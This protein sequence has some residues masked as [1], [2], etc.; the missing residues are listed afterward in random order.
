MFAKAMGVTAL[1]TVGSQGSAQPMPPPRRVPLPLFG[2]IAMLCSL[3]L[4]LVGFFASVEACPVVAFLD[5][6][7]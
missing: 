7:R 5:R 6:A 3:E 2:G 1:M 4:Q